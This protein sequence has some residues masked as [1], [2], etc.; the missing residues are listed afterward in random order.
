[1][2][3]APWWYLCFSGGVLWV[4]SAVLGV[5]L[6][7]RLP[8]APLAF[9]SGAL[10][11]FVCYGL[12]TAVLGSY[13][14]GLPSQVVRIVVLFGLGPVLV[15]GLVAARA[16]S[17]PLWRLWPWEAKHPGHLTPDLEQAARAR[18]NPPGKPGDQSAIRLT[19]DGVWEEG[20]G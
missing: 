7:R 4:L 14:L 15:A 5:T 9:L 16:Q 19:E 18:F 10:I 3:T 8:N 2:L 13:L 20:D 12:G 11:A 17:K 1:M 6:G